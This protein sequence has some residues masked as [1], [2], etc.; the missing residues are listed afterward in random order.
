M[1]DEKKL[2]EG[3]N[4]EAK[5]EKT[6]KDAKSAKKKGPGLGTRIAKF[7]RDT[8]GEFKKI[9]WPTFP[10]VVRNTGVTMA[11]CVILG[12]FICLFDWGL[13]ALINLMVSQG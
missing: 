9:V 3:E 6:E 2:P 12:A 1:A 13:G 8:R 7:F 4:T 11:M 10:T 5:V